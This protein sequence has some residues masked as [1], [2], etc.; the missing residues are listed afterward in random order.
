MVIAEITAQFCRFNEFVG[1]IWILFLSIILIAT[2]ID[3]AG[4][5]HFNLKPVDCG[6]IARN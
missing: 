1:L 6:S 2:E 3:T 4:V 5:E